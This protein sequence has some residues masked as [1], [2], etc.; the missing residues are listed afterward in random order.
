[1]K[2]NDAEL[3]RDLPYFLRSYIDGKQWT[4]FRE[5]QKQ[6]FKIL[7]ESSNHLIISAGTSSGK[8]EAA[9]F[10][11]IS[12]IYV[13]KPKRI[14]ALYISPLIALIDDQYDRLSRMIRD[15]G[16]NIYSWHSG[17][18]SSVKHKVLKNADGILQITPES[19]ENVVNRNYVD[20]KEM[21]SDLRFIIIDEVHTFMNSDRGLHLLCELDAIEKIAGCHPR[22]IGLSAT[23]S[24]FNK[25][26]EWIC[27]NTGRGVVIVNCPDT[28]DYNL[29]IRYVQLGPKGTP[30]RQTTLKKYYET[31]YEDTFDYNCLIF[32]NNRTTVENTVI[33]LEKI[34]K[35]RGTRKEIW[36]HHSSISKEYRE[37]TENRLKDPDRKCTAVSTSTLELGID[38]G[39]LDRTIQ[40]NAPYSVSSLVQKF[41]RSGRRNGRPIMICYCDNKYPSKLEGI[42]TDLIKCIAESLLFLNEHWI[43]PVRYSKLPYSLL[44]QQT[45][46][47]IRPRI[48]VTE[49]ELFNDVLDLY[50]FRNI[51]KNDY[52]TLL[53]HL[54]TIDILDYNRDCGTYILGSSG[55]RITRHFDFGTNFRTIK[56]YD[57]CYGEHLIGTIQSLP[58]EGQLIQLA[59]NSWQIVSIDPKLQEVMVIPTNTPTETFW[60][61]GISDVHTKILKKMYDCLVSDEEYPFLDSNARCHLRKSRMAFRKQGLDNKL[62]IYGNSLRL[63]PWLGTIQL[64]TLFRILEYIGLADSY[65]PPFSIVI[66][67]E[68]NDIEAIK[69][70]VNDF[71]SMHDP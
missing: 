65:Q 18:S 10:P 42:E 55:D 11:V 34:N 26:K 38:I 68:F 19:L 60:K 48:A 14:S 28:P 1:M 8:T 49:L 67:D 66:K 62:T 51:S 58:P 5:V 57:V 56:E 37:E 9:F 63:L 2:M 54:L 3:Y 39:E 61:S 20:V 33:G 52:R 44:F 13:Q 15:S 16:I 31:L 53:H 12:H 7:N 45:L 17:V 27:S 29:T 32:A 43:E 59:G 46:S 4:S 6:S 64:D 21:F 35:I 69:I 36:A 25:A 47:Y 22:R 50:P 71:I 23:L 24:D 40:I 30:E 41:G 70:K